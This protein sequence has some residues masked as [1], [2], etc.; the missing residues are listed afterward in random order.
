MSHGA[1]FAKPPKSPRNGAQPH[2]NGNSK[3][4]AITAERS[5]VYGNAEDAF[6]A[7][8]IALTGLIEAH[9]NIKLPHAIPPHVAGLVMVMIKAIRAARPYDYNEDTYDDMENFSRL[10]KQVDTRR[11]RKE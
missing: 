2:L 10:S 7:T 8:G 11:E 5:K 9:Y 1:S 6:R 3:L 4:D